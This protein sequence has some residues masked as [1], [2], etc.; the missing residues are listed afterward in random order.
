MSTKIETRKCYELI[1]KFFN[2]DKQK[3]MDWFSAPNPALGFLIPLQMVK[4]GRSPKLLSFI[5]S[6]LDE[7]KRP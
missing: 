6:S 5:K 4:S 3:I 1:H 2:G 7:N